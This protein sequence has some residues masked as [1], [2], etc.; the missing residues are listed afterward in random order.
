MAFCELAGSLQDP[1]L[2]CREL[3]ELAEFP[4]QLYDQILTRMF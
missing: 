1:A 3:G 4:K 2:P